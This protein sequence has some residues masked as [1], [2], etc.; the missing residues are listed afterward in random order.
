M[1]K[2]NF[3]FLILGL[4]LLSAHALAEPVLNIQHWKTKNGVK[5]FFVRAPQLPMLDLQ[6]TFTAGSV[7]DRDLYGLSELTSGMIGEGTPTMNSDQIAAAFDAIGAQFNTG[8]D[9]D[10]TTIS[11]RTLTDTDYLS[12]AISLFRDVVLEPTFPLKELQYEKN[13][14]LASIKIDEQNPAAIAKKIFYQKMYDHFGY[15]HSPEGTSSS[16]LKITQQEIIH[17]YRQYYVAK[18][19]YLILVGDITYQ[20]AHNIAKKVTEK[21]PQGELAKKFNVV[22]K[23]STPIIK[24]IAFPSKQTTIIVGQVGITRHNPS[25]FPLMVGNHILGGSGLTSI[26]YKQ[27]REKRGFAYAVGSKFLLW[28]YRGPFLLFLQTKSDQTKAALSVVKSTLQDFLEKGPSKE[29]LKAAKLNLIGSFPIALDSNSK[30]ESAVSNIAFYHLPLNYL[31]HYRQY[32]DK[33]SLPE[34]KKSFQKEI[35]LNKLI[36][37]TVGP[38]ESEG[39][40][41]VK[42]K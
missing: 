24:H 37:I 14:A 29:Q 28:R 23:T 17:F 10:M 20:Q 42:T 32:V 39:E 13:Q 11:L 2:N 15:A 21:L 12:K 38:N 5:V 41:N 27:I 8:V 36:I 22:P 3:I 26:L 16:I 40:I 33:V 30:I 6:L 34:I 19:A 9:R 7:Y 18:N 35:N 4:C 25:Y 31:D 1:K